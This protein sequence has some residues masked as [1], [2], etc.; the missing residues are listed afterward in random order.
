MKSVA[1]HHNI[2]SSRYEGEVASPRLAAAQ[3]RAG[4]MVLL[5]AA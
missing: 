2:P 4:C 3:I 5:Q 1:V